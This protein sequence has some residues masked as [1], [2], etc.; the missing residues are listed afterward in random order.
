MRLEEEVSTL[1]T[2]TT[3]ISRRWPPSIPLAVMACVAIWLGVPGD[4][5]AH[6]RPGH[7]SCQPTN[8]INYEAVFSSMPRV[9]RP[10]QSGRL[11]FG[12]RNLSFYRTS[13][14]N[15]LP[16]QA[17]FGYSMTRV[18]NGGPFR[19][20]WMATTRVLRLNRSGAPIGVEGVRRS[21]VAIGGGADRITF[22][23]P[24]ERRGLYRY[25]LNLRTRAGNWLAS[26]SEYFRVLP[27]RFRVSLS[28]A[29]GRF[30]P[31]GTAMV[32]VVNSGTVSVGYGGNVRV[33]RYES[34]RW[35]SARDVIEQNASNQ[36]ITLAP[37]VASGCQTLWV[38][39]NV[40]P[41]KYRLSLL[42]SRLDRRGKRIVR[43]PFYIHV[44]AQDSIIQPLRL[45]GRCVGSD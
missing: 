31:G 40:T 39:Q 16:P 5:T 38:N 7:R 29:V 34:G 44:T 14:T 8:V 9:N 24:I 22:A 11:P 36:T 35:V 21:R 41:G 19:P 27:A 45:R 30:E 23:V 25:D 17:L 12:P 4:I 33:E 18:G 15:V 32:R 28:L 20:G 2:R 37:G 10:P 13:S 26:Y 1:H 6:A 42:I 43:L 3:D